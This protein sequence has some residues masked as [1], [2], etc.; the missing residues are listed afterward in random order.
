[1]RQKFVAALLIS[2]AILV[3][4]V[5]G[6]PPK[7]NNFYPAGCQRGQSVIITAAGDFS[8]W[9]VQA[10]AD[11][12]GVV[13]TAEKEKGKFKAEVAAD[14]VPGVYWLRLHNADGRS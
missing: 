13:F 7:V 9:P 11:R 5:N 3:E 10:W 12:A 2:A 1:M 14:A 8:T 4:T 6:A